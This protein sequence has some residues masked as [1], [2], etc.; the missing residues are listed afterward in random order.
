MRS[1]LVWMGSLVAILPAAAASQS[2]D[3][4]ILP[5]GF[6]V[7]VF[8]EDLD[9]P[10]GM[11]FGADG[12]LFVALSGDGRVV[13]LPDRDGNGQADEV[14]TVLEHLNQPSGIAWDG[15]AM[16]VA[17]VTRVIRLD[18]GVAPYPRSDY[19]IVLKELPAG[20]HWTRTIL[21]EPSGRGFFLSIGASCD[22]CQEEDPRRAAIVHYGRDGSGEQIWASG[23]RNAVGLAFN[24]E[25]G[26]LWATSSGRDW[27]G[28]D[29]PP[30]ELNAIRRGRHYGW[31]YCYGARVPNP[32]YDDQARCDRTEPPISEFPAHSV[33]LGIVF[34]EG[35]MFPAEFRGDAFVALHGSWNRSIPTGYKVVRLRVEAGRP[36]AVEDFISG[37]LGVGGRIWGRPVQPLVGPDGALYVS[38]DHGGRIWRIIYEGSEAP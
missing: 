34:Y 17:D 26:E 35:A 36:V 18:G 16:W 3:A 29:L 4:L 38:D 11:V 8:A 25:T 19:S 27:L 28:D 10:R 32:E 21:L 33:P 24:P 37:W 23:L 5:E 6:K 15:T 22:L 31:P 7:Q 13:M 1:A 2:V 12:V 9:S 14:T 30:D 20:G